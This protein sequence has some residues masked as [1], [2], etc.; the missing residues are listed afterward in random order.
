MRMLAEETHAGIV[1]SGSYYEVADSLR[2]NVQVHDVRRNVPLAPLEPEVGPVTGAER[3]IQKLPQRV[4][5]ALAARLDVRL[6]ETLGQETRPPTFEAY[7]YFMAAMDLYTRNDPRAAAPLFRRAFEQD[8]TFLVSQLFL[9]L[10]HSN[11]QEWGIADSIL[12]TVNQR[13]SELTPYHA[14]WL[15]YRL[16]LLARD[17]AG[18]LVA[19]RRA[20]EIAPGSKAAYNYAA[21]ALENGRPGEA[22]DALSMIDPGR[23]AMRGWMPYWWLL[24][25]AHHAMGG[26][27]DEKKDV[28][29]AAELYPDRLVPIALQA[30]VAA[31]SGDADRVLR[32]LRTGDRL[33]QEERGPSLGGAYVDSGAELRAH[34]YSERSKAVIEGAVSWYASLPPDRAAEPDARWQH[35]RALHLLGRMHDARNQ[36][37]RLIAE[38]PDQVDYRGLQGLIAVATDSAGVADAAWTWL[39]AQGAAP[40]QFGAPQVYQARLAA[41]RDQPDLA[42]RKLREAFE[43]GRHYGVWIHVAPE[44]ET[45]KDFP[46][47]LEVTSSREGR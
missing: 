38:Y 26:L 20:A 28:E 32:L 8:S 42:I 30:R 27:R 3:I 13:R 4:A 12:R 18:A 16:A 6:A 37:D 41:L 2:F 34:G 44:F 5:G 17:R 24:A 40:F 29:K 36:V 21:E 7:R 47:F 23:G 33:R 14:A 1:V 19:I 45:L 22:I 31:A 46:A 43:N 11:L 15:D 10:N 25:E 35:V 39:E 9:A